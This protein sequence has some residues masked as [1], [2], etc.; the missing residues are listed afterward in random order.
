MRM[1]CVMSVLVPTFILATVRGKFEQ[2][3]IETVQLS[4]CTKWMIQA[5]FMNMKQYEIPVV[6]VEQVLSRKLK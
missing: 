1:K 5:Y 2:A 6:N 3:I 4:T